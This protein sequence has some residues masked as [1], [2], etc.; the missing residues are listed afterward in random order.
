MTV[1]SRT[2]HATTLRLSE[3]TA[4]RDV[5]RAA[6]DG[7][8]EVDRFELHEPPLAEIFRQAVSGTHAQA[9]AP[10]F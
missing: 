5:L 8:A 3:G 10:P 2:V 6:L 1:L 9:S 4:A 7:S